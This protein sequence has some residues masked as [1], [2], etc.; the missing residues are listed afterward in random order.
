LR[1]DC[2]NA[3]ISPTTAALKKMAL[4]TLRFSDAA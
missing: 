2:I 3:R 1:R 4:L